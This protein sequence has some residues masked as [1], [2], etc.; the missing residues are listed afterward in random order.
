MIKEKLNQVY[1]SD[2]LGGFLKYSLRYKG[3][4]IWTIFISSL[5]SA[6]GAAPAWLTK[7][8]VDDV[9]ISKNGKVMLLIG[10]AIFATTVLKLITAY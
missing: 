1:K 6:L 5:S 8:L 9:L 4:L 3:W 10:I 7:Y 2:A